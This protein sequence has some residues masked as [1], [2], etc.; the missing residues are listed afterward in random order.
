MTKVFIPD[1][2]LN[3]AH[4]NYQYYRKFIHIL[5]FCANFDNLFSSSSIELDIFLLN[6]TIIYSSFNIL[7]CLFILIPI[8][9]SEVIT[10]PFNYMNG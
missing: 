8:R 5:V 10:S 4:K 6:M 9:G 3:V 7:V 1:I 2:S